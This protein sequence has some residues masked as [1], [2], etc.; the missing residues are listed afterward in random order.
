MKK[1]VILAIYAIFLVILG[2]GCAPQEVP[3][4]NV[5]EPIV[6]DVQQEAVENPKPVV[7]EKDEPAFNLPPDQDTSP[8]WKQTSGPLGGVVNRMIS[9]DGTVWASLYSGGIYELQTDD[10]WKQIAVGHGI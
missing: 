5:S 8:G 3:I 2:S 4:G 7:E 10:S 1:E 9:H 6:E